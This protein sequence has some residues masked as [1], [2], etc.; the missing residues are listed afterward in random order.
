YRAIT[1]HVVRRFALGG[2]TS[3]VTMACVSSS[4][5]IARAV[6]AIRRGRA[7]VMLAGGA[8]S[9]TNLS[10]SGFS[11]LHAMTRSLC[12]P[13]DRRRDGMV[14]G[15]GAAL[16]VLEEAEH[17]A[18]RGAR[19]YAELCG[20]G[21]GGDAHHPTGPHPEG[22]GLSAAIATALADAGLSP[23]DVDHVNLHGTGT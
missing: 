19:L 18:R 1:G 15:E 14:L 5:A 22:R 12:R 4:L 2:P 13:F 6:E 10:F 23:A 17:A 7:Q 9:L 3:T 11:V 8:D 20:W 21:S 16:L